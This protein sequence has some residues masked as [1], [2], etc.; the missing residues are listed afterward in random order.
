MITQKLLKQFF[1]YNKTTGVFTRRIATGR[2]GCHK[3]GSA[4]GS[5][6]SS[7]GYIRTTVNS[8]RYY[9]HRLAWLYVTGSFP[10]YE[11]DHIDGS[12]TN[13]A[14]SNLRSVTHQENTKNQTKRANKSGITGV[15]MRESGKWSAYITIDG[16]NTTIGIYSLLKDAVKARKSADKKHGFHDNHGKDKLGKGADVI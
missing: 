10:E 16:N 11:I 14:I 2:H 6:D 12:R 3:K 13:N 9:A 4:V 5:I 8:K 1:F 7:N 15:R